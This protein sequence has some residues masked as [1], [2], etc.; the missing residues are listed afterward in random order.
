MG[1]VVV[2]A[3]GALTSLG[4]ELIWGAVLPWAPG[5][6]TR[7]RPSLSWRSLSW[8]LGKSGK[9]RVVSSVRRGVRVPRA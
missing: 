8:Q 2:G 1:H 9:G 5:I 3:A 7:R 6:G 4:S